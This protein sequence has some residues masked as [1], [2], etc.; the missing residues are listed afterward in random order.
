MVEKRPLTQ[1]FSEAPRI[2][3]HELWVSLLGVDEFVNDDLMSNG[4]WT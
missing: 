4:I 1:F 2:W 3:L